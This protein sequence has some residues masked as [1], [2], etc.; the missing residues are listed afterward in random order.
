MIVKI[1]NDYAQAI[2]NNKQK[3]SLS[4]YNGKWDLSLYDYS[5]KFLIIV[6]LC[7]DKS[8]LS[9]INKYAAKYGVQFTEWQQN[10]GYYDYK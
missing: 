4:R 8:R 2:I 10:G 1:K 6:D 3:L 7:K 5:N 9:T